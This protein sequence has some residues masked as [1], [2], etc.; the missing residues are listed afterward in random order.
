MAAKKT[1][2]KKKQAKGPKKAELAAPLPADYKPRLM[3]LYLTRLREELRQEL[4]LENVMQVPRLT[5][6]VVNMGVGEGSRDDKVMLA[7]EEDLTQITGQKPRRNRAKLSVA[8]FKLRKGMP[9]GCSVTLR[10]WRMYEFL[11]RMIAVAIPRIRDFRGLSPRSFDGRGNFSFG[12]REHLIFTEVDTR[13]RTHSFGMDITLVTTA[14]DDKQS[15]AL[16]TKLGMPLR[17]N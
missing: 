10:G 3:E 2:D 8:A 4:G 5:K 15:R 12:V 14:R 13:D 16:L 6:I 17:E 1:E 9:V 11:E 7:A